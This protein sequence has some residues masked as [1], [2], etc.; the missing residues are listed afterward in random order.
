MG[1]EGVL[2]SVFFKGIFESK[3]KSNKESHHCLASKTTH[4]Y[5]AD[6]LVYQEPLFGLQTAL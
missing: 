3:G 4:S 6:S 2:C 5:P 1:Q